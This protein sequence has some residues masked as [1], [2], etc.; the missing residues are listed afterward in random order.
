MKKKISFVIL[1]TT[2]SAA[3]QF[4]LSRAALRWWVVVAVGLIGSSAFVGADYVRL[5]RD[6][7]QLAQREAE[8]SGLLASQGGEVDLQRRQISEFAE[9][10]NLLK[11]KLQALNQFEKKIRIMADIEK[12]PEAGALFGVGGSIPTTMDPKAVFT[13][14]RNSLMREMHA[15]TAQL[16]LAMVHQ[17]DSFNALVTH[18]ERQQRLLA[19]TPTIR[20][21]DPAA[22]FWVSSKFEWR[23]S[24]F[25]NQ[26]EF[27]KGYDIAAREGTPI[28]ATAGGVVTF[29]GNR[30]LLGKTL[31]IDH[32]HGLTTV[33]GH[34]SRLLKSQGEK[35]RRWDPVGLVGNTGNSTGPHLHYEVWV[36]GVPVN[37]EKYFLN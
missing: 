5:K 17:E 35:V 31:I 23:I 36:H 28:F 14:Q 20:P 21:I 13:E 16:D 4:C 15:Q 34:C 18:L 2:G 7:L 9:Q 11:D 3:K 19:S 8:L 33:Y 32:G 30:G 1:A 24:P 6:A 22:E 29:A 37:P 26:R 25:T 10:I 12:R 27:H